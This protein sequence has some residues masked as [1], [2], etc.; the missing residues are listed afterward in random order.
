M[1]EPLKI[2]LWGKE[3]G[4]LVW[5]SRMNNSY[6]TYNPDFLKEGVEIA[7][8][9]ASVKGVKGRFPVYGESD[10]KYQKLPPFLADSLPDDWGNQLFERWRIDNKLSNADI[11]PLEK[12]SFIGKRG[13]GALEFVPDVSR[14]SVKE[15]IDIPSLVEL[16]R[17]I[18][19]ERENA[20]ILPEESLTMQSLIA[21]GTSAGGRQPKAILAVNRENG[22]IRSGQIAGLK[23]Y[24]YCILKFGDPQRCSAE[25]EMAYYEMCRHAGI[26]VMESRLLEVDGEKHFLTKRFDR[27]GEEKLHTQT[28]AALC[29]GT[30]SYEKLLGVC[31]KMRLPEKDAE[32]VFRRMVFNILANNTDDHDK[33]F[34]FVMD[35]Q[36]RWRLSPAYDMTFIFNTGGYQPQEE[37]CFMVRG[38]LVGITRQDALDFAKDNGIRRAE[39]I[40]NDVVEAIKSF[41]DIAAGYGVKEEWIGRIDSC[42]SQ[43]LAGWGCL[44]DKENVG[45]DFSLVVDNH[46]VHVR[47]EQ[48]YKGNYHLLASVDGRELKYIFRTGTETHGH[49]E[50]K[51]IA[52]LSSE[53]ILQ[54]VRTYIMPKLEKM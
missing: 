49:I 13:M 27:E 47:I 4:R 30:D 39:S 38:K 40:M 37:R 35:K 22:E 46:T 24:D 33:N 20:R 21:V 12:L 8:L 50:R 7:P 45:G 26:D 44:P 16:A 34:S 53:D 54:M 17:R 15:R 51:G 25:L 43:H 19:T 23:G 11:T 6:F 2:F 36:G 10:R 29:P 48:A 41:K 9:T 5:D 32:E 52:G 28:L 3:I 14:A 18:F 1:K 31:R 42:L